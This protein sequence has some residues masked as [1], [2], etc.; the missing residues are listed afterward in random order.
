MNSRAYEPEGLEF[1]D[2]WHSQ[3]Y[4]SAVGVVD[5]V[6]YKT[7]LKSMIKAKL[8]IMAIKNPAPACRS[9]LAEDIINVKGIGKKI[10]FVENPEH[11][12]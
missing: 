10:F 4:Y 2:K 6:G 12:H 7:S 5:R 3:G 1:S 8:Y 9:W 11:N